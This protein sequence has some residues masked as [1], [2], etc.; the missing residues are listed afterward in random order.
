MIKNRKKVDENHFEALDR[1]ARGLTPE[2]MR[3]L[4]PAMRHRS[5]LGLRN[6]VPRKTGTLDTWRATLRLDSTA[7]TGSIPPPEGASDACFDVERSGC[8]PER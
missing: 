6:R 2:K 7:R 8:W 4:S 5:P 1:L 3:P